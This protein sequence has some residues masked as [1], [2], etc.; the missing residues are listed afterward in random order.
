MPQLK[1]PSKLSKARHSF[2]GF[3]SPANNR[4]LCGSRRRQPSRLDA[5]LPVSSAKIFVRKSISRRVPQ[6][7]FRH[8]A[9][10]LALSPVGQGALS[11]VGQGESCATSE[12]GEF[13]VVECG[14]IMRLALLVILSDKVYEKR[15]LM[16][17]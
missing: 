5:D 8:V 4:G 15:N 12:D 9:A 13:A 1:Y 7:E 17:S 3:N 2:G 6:G 10:T 14:V 16:Q 11:P